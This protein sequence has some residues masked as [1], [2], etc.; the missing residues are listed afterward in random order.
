[1]VWRVW[2]DALLGLE[3]WKDSLG[4]RGGSFWAM[5]WGGYG[6][7]DQVGS[8]NKMGKATAAN[9]KG[10]AGFRK[11][12]GAQRVEP[13]PRTGS[14]ETAED[15]LGRGT[16]ARPEEQKKDPACGD[17]IP[18]VVLGPEAETRE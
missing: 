7:Q 9:P 5:G 2:G 8:I 16:R 3:N 12:D 13:S 4:A 14:E 6:A 18:E 10:T 15:E 1:M 11:Q 17:K